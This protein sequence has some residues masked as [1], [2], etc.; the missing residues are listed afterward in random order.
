MSQTD[1]AELLSRTLAVFQWAIFKKY[2]A[3]RE[4]FG[5]LYLLMT[6]K[7]TEAGGF[8]EIVEELRAIGLDI[9]CEV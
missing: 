4:D 1:F 7:L 5:E 3:T 9:D 6:L 2:G 8:N